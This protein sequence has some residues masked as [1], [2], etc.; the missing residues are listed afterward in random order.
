MKQL[1]SYSPKVFDF[2]NRMS[3]TVTKNHIELNDG[4]YGFL[5]L[6]GD[7]PFKKI[8]R[9]ELAEIEKGMEKS[10][11]LVRNVI[12]PSLRRESI[13]RDIRREL[14]KVCKELIS[15]SKRYKVKYTKIVDIK[16]HVPTKF[17]NVV[18]L[19]E[20]AYPLENEVE[21]AKSALEKRNKTR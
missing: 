4:F 11:N 5:Q 15:V 20:R 8:K 21:K 14:I 18:T 9:A 2:V 3:E 16:A 6:Y 17:R 19:F 10:I 7:E 12:K 1:E 13:D